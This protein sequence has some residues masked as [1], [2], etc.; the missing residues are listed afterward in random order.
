MVDDVGLPPWAKGDPR[1]FIELHRQ[2]LESEYVTEH[3]HEWIDLIFGYKQR[4]EAAIEAINCFHELSYDDGV[5]LHSIESSVERQAALK[6][7]HMFGV[8]PR[9][10]FNVPHPARQPSDALKPTLALTPWL[11]VQSILP[12]RTLRS[13]SV[14]FIYTPDVSAK[15]FASPRDY[16]VLADLGLSISVGHLDNSMRF[17]VKDNMNAVKSVTEQILPE[18]ISCIVDASNYGSGSLG[19]GNEAEPAVQNAHV[20][21]GG[22]GG[23]FVACQ[24]DVSRRDLLLRYAC[25]GH[26]DAILTLEYSHAWSLTVSGSQDGTAIIWDARGNYVK[27]LGHEGPVQAVQTCPRNGLIATA[28]GP[29]LHLWSVNGN[30]IASVSTSAQDPIASVAFDD[31]DAPADVDDEGHAVASLGMILTGHRGKVIVWHCRSKREHP[32]EAKDTARWA[33][34]PVYVL[35]HRDR[36]E[37]ALMHE[38]GGSTHPL[39][40]AIKVSG[41]TVVTGDDLGRLYTWNLPGQAPAGDWAAG[42]SSNSSSHAAGGNHCMQCSRKFGVFEKRNNCGACGGLFCATCAVS[43]AGSPFGPHRFCTPCRDI[44]AMHVGKWAAIAS[45]SAATTHS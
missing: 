8:C 9:Q 24:V 23:T 35:E 18:R 37:E 40:T 36:A 22:L 26:S 32:F 13:S 14:H 2:A 39:I 6:T 15:P 21:V 11:L 20:L 7:I 29:M 28:S 45:R 1:L 10:L 19:V 16:L 31:D 27:T 43:L 44:L 42:A 4:G 34:E 5:D 41:D 38:E 17:Y 12:V 30:A 33:L 25:R 3:L